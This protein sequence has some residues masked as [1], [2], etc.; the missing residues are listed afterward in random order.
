MTNT[1]EL[2]L[3]LREA[4]QDDPEQ[5]DH[6]RAFAYWVQNEHLG[7]DSILADLAQKAK[8]LSG[9]ARLSKHVAILGYA[10]HFDKAYSDAFEEGLEWL[11]ARKYFVP[12]RPGNFEVDGLA[13][14]GVAIGIISLKAAESADKRAWLSELVRQSLGDSQGGVDWNGSLISGAAYVL[15]IPTN[16]KLP[17]EL[18]VS[19]S[20]KQLVDATTEDRAAAWQQAFDL[21]SLDGGMTQA[22]MR[23]AIITFL[24]REGPTIRLDQVSIQD[25]GRLL[26]G[27]NRSLRHWTWEEKA[28]TPQSNVAK[29]EV[30][31]EYHVQ[32]FLWAVLAPIFPDL[33]DEEWLKSLGHHHPRG[34]F[35][36]PSLR[37]VIEAKFLR[38]GSGVF[39]KVI[40]EIAADASTYLR[41]DSGYEHLIPVIWDDYARTEQHAELHRGIMALRGITDVI[42]LSRP[43]VMRR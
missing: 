35:A 20:A 7:P 2:P 38:A 31:N 4:A 11:S 28:R 22:A 43:S 10:C 29:W 24:S 26:H 42:I 16:S 39:S 41:P 25:V 40:Q 21:K 33:D 6:A 34:D 23:A 36:I 15:S 5:P 30:E 1:S 9:P 18:I 17:A 19:L 14:L 32:N 3:Y 37:L 8:K 27:L 13:L 12:G